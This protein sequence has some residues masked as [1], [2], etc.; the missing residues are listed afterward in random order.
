MPYA[1]FTFNQVAPKFKAVPGPR[2]QSVMVLNTSAETYPPL[3]SRI[4]SPPDLDIYSADPAKRKVLLCDPSGTATDAEIF[5]AFP[6]IREPKEIEIRAEG[7]K[8]L[9]MLAAPYGSEERES[10]ATQQ[11]EAR[12]WL[13]DNTA[14]IPMITAMAEARNITV[15]EMVGKIMENVALFETMAGSILGT[16]Q[17]LLDLIYSATTY[18]AMQ[19]VTW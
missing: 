8:R 1:I 9:K 4:Y 13:A 6:K 3:A 5:A 12:A 16:Q 14:P 18:D 7:G 17:H 10:W 15:A 19:G 2:G 11:R